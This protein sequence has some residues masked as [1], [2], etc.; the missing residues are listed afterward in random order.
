MPDLNTKTLNELDTITEMGENDK[1]LVESNGR[2]K[3]FSGEIG[4]SGSGVYILT[5][6]DFNVDSESG[7]LTVFNTVI[8]NDLFEAL[9]TGITVY[10]YEDTDDYKY[11]MIKSFSI[12]YS[13][14]D[15]MIYVSTD[16]DAFSIKPSNGYSLSDLYTPT[17]IIVMSEDPVN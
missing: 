16:Y 12:W 13:N 17:N 14:N 7:E 11:Y 15:P 9:D 3:K 2:M 6:H 5:S 1:V 10:L 8:F 4:G